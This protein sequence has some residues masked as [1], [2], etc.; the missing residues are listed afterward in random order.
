MN[1]KADEYR[2]IG[3]QG[4]EGGGG[5][6]PPH[7][8]KTFDSFKNPTFRLYFG[9]MAC[10]WLSMN[11]QMVARSLLIYRI[12]GSGA[13]LGSLALANAIPMLLLSLFGGAVADRVQKKNVL[14]VG[15]AGS[16]MISLGIAAALTLGYLSPQHPDS[17]WL[18][19]ASAALQGIVMGFMMPA[20]AAIVPEIVGPEQVMNAIS[21]NNLGMSTFQI[22]ASALAGFI[23]D[24][25]DFD[26]AYY[27]ITGLYCIG[28]VGV[29]FIPHTRAIPVGQGSALKDILEGVRY[30]R[31]ETTV[32][33]ILLFATLGTIFGQPHRLMMPMFTE[34]ILKVGATGLGLLMTVSGIGALSGSLVL[35][36]L[37]NRN[38][39]FILLLSGLTMG[40]AL[41][42]FSFSH[43][44][45]LSLV[46]MFFVGLGQTGQMTMGN[47]L[48]QYHTDASYRGRVMSFFMMGMG[49]ASLGTFFGGM[50]AEAVGI[51][52]SIGGMATGL[53]L[54]SIFMLTST[55]QLRKLD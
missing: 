40:L 39:G 41:V 15:Q 45:Y 50:L 35:A 3:S 17:W 36:S 20:R 27:I 10:Q 30:I 37:P 9:T 51:Q 6:I 26:A 14:I 1:K 48:L 18:L 42:A 32:F 22:M 4:A 46:L 31:V 13:I 16:A 52:W 28:A 24:A 2:G 34:D 29:V 33:L 38:R 25:F 44:W 23:I 53:T 12:S 54:M 7:R 11:I 49:L 5:G 43:W 21:L 19:V 8:L 47:A 55:P